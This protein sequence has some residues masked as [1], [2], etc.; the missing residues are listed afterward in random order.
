[1]SQYS[2]LVQL[3]STLTIPWCCGGAQPSEVA[4]AELQPRHFPMGR[5]QPAEQQPV[6]RRPATAAVLT[7]C[8]NSDAEHKKTFGLVSFTAWAVLIYSY[9]CLVSPGSQQWLPSGWWLVR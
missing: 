6:T 4:R 3:G 5:A 8:G 9:S 1:M 2:V 7:T